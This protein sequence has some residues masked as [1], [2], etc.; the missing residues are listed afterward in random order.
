MNIE[1]LMTS[2]SHLVLQQSRNE[3]SAYL[4]KALHM[5]EQIDHKPQ[6]RESLLI[7]LVK[8]LVALYKGVIN[9][10]K[11]SRKQLALKWHQK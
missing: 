4:K 5:V 9:N 8:L 2:E 7:T 3:E 10:L 11:A 1:K 6:F